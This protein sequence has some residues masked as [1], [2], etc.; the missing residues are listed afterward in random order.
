M[1]DSRFFTVAGPFSLGELAEISGA[2]LREGENKEAIFQNVS[3]LDEA[4]PQDVGFLDNRRYADA[5]FVSKA[6][7]CLV[8]PDL[9]SRAPEG[10]ALLVTKEPY[11]GY[12]RIAQAFYPLP[13][14]ALAVSPLAA[15]DEAAIIGDGC[16]IGPGSAIAAGAEIG[17]DTVIGAN[18]VVGPGVVIGKNCQIGPQVC[19]EYSL[20]GD[21]VI[22]HAG[23]SIGQDGFGFALGPRGH[24]KIP[25]LG[26]V[27]IENDVEIGANV[28]IDRGAG[29]DTVVGEGSKIDN[30]VQI[31]HNARLGRGCVLVSLS[32]ISGST[33]VGDLVMMGGQAGLA[34]HLQ[35]GDGAR[36][37]AQSGVMRDVKAG[38]SVGGY[39]A[40][41]M[42][43]WLKGVAL[44]RHMV[45]K[46]GK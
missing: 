37:A 35:I 1:V 42:R 16:R 40:R 41:P 3:S 7:A 43:E 34:G 27:I 20:I 17:A 32:G 19:I 30:L 26:R 10:M 2:E 29:P 13:A 24:L 33:K 6:G 11:H 12:A 45:K 36:I 18:A 46:K 44:L 39:P 23:S 15:V 5:F 14:P 8:H 25:Q 22:I 9:A 31:G 28:T 21:D 38:E 4:G